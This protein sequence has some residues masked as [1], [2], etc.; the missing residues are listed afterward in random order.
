MKTSQTVAKQHCIQE[1]SDEADGEYTEPTS[2]P[3]HSGVRHPVVPVPAKKARQAR[4][5]FPVL[6]VLV[7]GLL[8]AA[9]AWIAVEYGDKQP[10]S[11]VATLPAQNAPDS[12][13]EQ[14]TLPAQEMDREPTT[15]SGTGGPS[16]QDGSTN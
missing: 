11:P 8:L 4:P 10:S 13:D 15:Q 16:Q 7:S 2:E 1:N 12:T 6:V 14:P 9:A 3:V 5:G